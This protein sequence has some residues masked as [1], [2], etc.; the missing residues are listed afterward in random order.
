MNSQFMLMDIYVYMTLIEGGF[1][2]YY[3]FE[4]YIKSGE[5]T[6]GWLTNDLLI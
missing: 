3:G 2:I 1:A 4:G 6:T 5:R